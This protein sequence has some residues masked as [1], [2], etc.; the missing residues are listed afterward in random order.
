MAVRRGALGDTLLFL[1]V[2]EA[3]RKTRPGEELLFVGH[4]D[5]L[6]LVSLAGLAERTLPAS[7]WPPLAELF[8][9]HGP[10]GPPPEPLAS[11]GRVLLEW[12]EDL[13]WGSIRLFRPHPEKGVRKPLTLQL[14]ARLGLEEQAA[15]PPHPLESLKATLAGSTLA[16]AGESRVFL[17]PGAGSARKTWPPDRFLRLGLLLEERGFLVQVLLGPA[18]RA[19]GLG[20]GFF[21]ERGL[22]AEI[23]TDVLELARRLAGATGYVGNDA[24]PSHLA[25]ALGVRSLVLFGPTDPVVWGPPWPGTVCLQAGGSW[26]ELE[27]E[28]VLEKFLETGGDAG[29]GGFPT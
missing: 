5:Y 24:G 21:L 29:E 11:A 3:F 7:A 16:G 15:W 14:L 25:A 23:V 1:P 13:E 20:E 19:R 6:D 28:T 2:L 8:R 9:G 10:P 22:A 26:G 12:E 4:G 18:E 27:V 17:H